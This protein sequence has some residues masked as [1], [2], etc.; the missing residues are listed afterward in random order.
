M[1]FKVLTLILSM[2]T[3]FEEVH[4]W[5]LNQLPAGVVEYL[6]SMHMHMSAMMVHGYNSSTQEVETGR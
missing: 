5:H 4:I 3:I 2:E 1:K 6:L